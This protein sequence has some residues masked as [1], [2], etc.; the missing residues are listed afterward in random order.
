MVLFTRMSNHGCFKSSTLSIYITQS[1]KLFC[2]RFVLA[3]KT[4][5]FVGPQGK[6]VNCEKG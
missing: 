1:T 6:C 3:V 5:R 2:F 4:A